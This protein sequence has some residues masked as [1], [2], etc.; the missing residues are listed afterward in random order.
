MQD[1]MRVVVFVDGANDLRAKLIQFGA[2]KDYIQ[3]VQ[4]PLNPIYLTV[5]MY[6]YINVVE[7]VQRT[8]YFKMI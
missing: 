3:S 4:R 6:F 1:D 5:Q 8:S 2:R 7:Y